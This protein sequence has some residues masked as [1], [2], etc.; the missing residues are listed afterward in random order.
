MRASS[1]A[2]RQK[3]CHVCGAGDLSDPDI[4]EALLRGLPSGPDALVVEEFGLL[5]GANRIDVAVID[6]SLHGYEI[7]S[8]LDTFGRLKKQITAY[9]RVLDWV[10]LV[11]TRKHVKAAV[12]WIPEWWGVTCAEADGLDVRL[13]E[14]RPGQ[15]N[16]APEPGAIV[17]LL[18][19]NE[20]LSLLEDLSLAKGVRGKPRKVLWDRLAGSI[21]PSTLARHVRKALRSRSDWK[22]VNK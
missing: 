17:Q 14:V 15:R 1:L 22:K 11:T 20:A 3:R 4:R 8:D 19:R 2:H 7:K 6:D 16:P 5:Q 9:G 13:T 12:L 18:W 10:V 21:P